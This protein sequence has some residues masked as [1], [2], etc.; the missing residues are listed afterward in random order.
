MTRGLD[1]SLILYPKKEWE[2]LALKLS[3]LPI[4][5][6]DSR[7]VARHFL[8]GAFEVEL[9]KQGRMMIPDY[10]RK[11]GNLTKRVVIAGLYNRIEIWDEAEWMDYKKNTEKESTSIAENLGELGV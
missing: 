6:S 7:A 9:D 8:S 2:S 3:S 11:F 4:T 10:L 5:K 1:Q